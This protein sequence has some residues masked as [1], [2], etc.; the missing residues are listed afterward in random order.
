MSKIKKENGISL[1]AL[2]VTIIVLLILAEI[3]LTLTFGKNGI[4]GSAIK[5]KEEYEKSAKNE[6]DYLENLYSSIKIADNEDA[7]ITINMKNLQSI[8]DERVDIK[9]QEKMTTGI[10]GINEKSLLMSSINQS[11]N[12]ENV[13][14]TS[15]TNTF[16]E[17]EFAKYFEYNSSNGELTCKEE[18]WF[19]VSLSLSMHGEPSD[20]CSQVLA[21]FINGVNIA[22]VRGSIT[23]KS[24]MS[25][26]ENN[27]TIYMKKG[28]KI[29]A[30]KQ[31]TNK[32]VTYRNT[33]SI[34]IFKI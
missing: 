20:Y 19:L 25:D 33:S 24:T 9:V 2:V 15:F 16:T 30:Q 4:I 23:S 13:N 28:D 1:V 12:V 32:A 3:A 7:E 26:D 5:A 10:T 21:L 34:T 11:L 29:T 18:G 6:Q 14:I 17:G 22:S 27:T 8:I 31:T